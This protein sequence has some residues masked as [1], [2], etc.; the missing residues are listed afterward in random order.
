MGTDLRVSGQAS[1]E[2][3]TMW[4]KI[5]VLAEYMQWRNPQRSPLYVYVYDIAHPR[6]AFH[7]RYARIERLVPFPYHFTRIFL[8]PGLAVR[9]RTNPAGR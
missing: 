4:V 7:M 5:Q 6:N 9:D 8:S 2:V 3:Y 1:R